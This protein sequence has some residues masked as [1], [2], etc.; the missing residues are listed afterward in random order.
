MTRQGFRIEQDTLGVRE[1]PA[2][3]LHGSQTDR[4]IENFRI[5]G[6]TLAELVVSL[7]AG[8]MAS[9]RLP[10]TPSERSGAFLDRLT[11]EA[12]RRHFLRPIGTPQAIDR[13]DGVR[14]ELD[15]GRTIHFRASGN[16]PELRCYTEAATAARADELLAWGLQ[17]AEREVR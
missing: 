4:A 6:R 16:A 9:D 5:S 12:F 13:Q 2:G 7:D 15:G 11:D 10:N 17:A 3:A 14:I 8:E 1:L